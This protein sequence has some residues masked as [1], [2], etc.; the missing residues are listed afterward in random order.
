[1][2]ISTRL[3]ALSGQSQQNIYREAGAIGWLEKIILPPR[4]ATT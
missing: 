3:Q 2:R 4:R 1:M